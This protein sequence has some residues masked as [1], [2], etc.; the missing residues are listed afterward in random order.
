MPLGMNVVSATLAEN[1][2]AWST[3]AV[4][5]LGL[6]ALAGTL[7]TVSHSRRDARR[8]RTLDYLNR[9]FDLEFAPLNTRVLTFLRTGDRNA[10]SPGARVTQSLPD[11][12]ASL[13]AAWKAYEEL[14]LESQ[15][16]IVLVLNFY[17]ELSGSYRAGLLD[18][19]IAEN[20]LAP[21]LQHGWMAATWFV[22]S[23][24]EQIELEH[25]SE[26]AGET[27]GEWEK[28]VRELEAGDKP[29]SGE[30][31]PARP[32]WRRIRL[33]W[34][35]LLLFAAGALAVAGLI[36]VALSGDGLRDLAAAALFATATACLVLVALSL[37]SLRSRN[38]LLASAAVTA[39]L[40]LSL[41]A[42]FALTAEGPPGPK[43]ERGMQGPVG[44]SGLKGNP[45]SEGRR[46][47]RGERGPRGPRGFPA[48][49]GS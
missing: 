19:E 41:T 35:T 9:L 20:M 26:L 2:E 13:E 23:A 32:W 39:L 7:L 38:V 21:V 47:P 3:F 31:P 16:R 36:V 44:E 33:P 37:A 46:G 14:D 29:G 28:L 6:P 45:G 25:G 1:V 24:R 48:T 49:L 27:A 34:L 40:S 22:G 5:L 4:A 15:A 12:P 10:F 30:D 18:D 43:G 17:E 11:Q 42:R 8:A